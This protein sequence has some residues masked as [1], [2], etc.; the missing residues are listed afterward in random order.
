M[1]SVVCE[2][3]LPGSFL[4]FSHNCASGLKFATWLQ[5][6]KTLVNLL[7]DIG[8]PTCCNQF[9]FSIIC[10]QLLLCSRVDDWGKRLGFERLPSIGKLGMCVCVCAFVPV[11][12]I[13]FRVCR[14][15]RNCTCS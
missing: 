14:C 6:C 5:G 2:G 3:T 4:T 1:G 10:V 12:A 15:P 7:S 9:F 8:R 11:G 13:A